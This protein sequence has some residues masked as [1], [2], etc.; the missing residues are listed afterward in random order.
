MRRR[1][2]LSVC[3]LAV[4]STVAAGCTDGGNGDGGDDG[5]GG[6]DNEI[7]VERV[8]GTLESEGAEVRE[9]SNEGDVVVLEYSPGELPDDADESEIEARVEETVR[10]VSGTFFEPIVGP[11]SGWE[12]DYLDASVTIDGTV[13]ATYRLETAW[14]EECSATGDTRACLEERVQGSVERPQQD[15]DADGGT[16]TE[17]STRTENET[18]TG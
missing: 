2:Y 16:G 12:A 5:D 15:D 3:G 13:V 11:G 9:L 4:A 14:A 18:A 17:T 10:A 8:R 7:M 1:R 6:L